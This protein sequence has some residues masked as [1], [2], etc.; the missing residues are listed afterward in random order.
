MRNQIL[1]ERYRTPYFR[2]VI[3]ILPNNKSYIVFKKI[4]KILKAENK[5]W[6]WLF[7]RLDISEATLKTY[8]SGRDNISLMSIEKIAEV[9][10]PYIHSPRDL[11]NDEMPILRLGKHFKL[12]VK[13]IIQKYGITQGEI[14]RFTDI[15]KSSVSLMA[16]DRL[17]QLGPDRLFILYQYLRTRGVPLRSPLDLIYFPEWGEEPGHF[18]KS[19][20]VRGTVFKFNSSINRRLR[21]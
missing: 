4:E 13:F 1:I 12:N 14:A 8:F 10:K 17:T 6:N 18:I 16:R 20:V 5:Q 11:M 7:K 19:K 21:S 15:E 2:S 9:L 3:E